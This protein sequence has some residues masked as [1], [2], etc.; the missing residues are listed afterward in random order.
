MG[1]NASVTGRTWFHGCLTAAMI[2][3]AIVALHPQPLRA[4]GSGVNPHMLDSGSCVSSIPDSA[5]TRT[6]VYMT[7]A[8]RNPIPQRVPS[9]IGNVMQAV[10]D[11]ADSALGSAPPYLPNGE[12]GVTWH[13]IGDGLLV[14]WHRDGTL[15]WTVNA[16]SGGPPRDT[17]SLAHVVAR[18]LAVT[19]ATGEV[20]LA[21]PKEAANDSVQFDV[22][23]ELSRVNPDKTL[24]PVDASFAIPILGVRAPWETPV[25]VLKQAHPIYPSELQREGVRATV[26]ISFVVDTSGRAD[27]AT[28]HDAWP[29]WRPR[30]TGRL[31][32]YYD[33]FYAAAARSIAEARF[34]PAT[35]AG[36]KVRQK[37]LQPFTWELR[38]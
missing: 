4:Q 21:W 32:R 23:F 1:S 9:M 12:P 8:V 7:V 18:S 2:A 3:A 24:A 10:V 29:S 36:C 6:V 16:D 26:R 33:Q 5:F 30:L 19:V 37:V 11:R 17:T 14:T 31:G 34:T 13:D 35:I 20:Y 28:I 27:P 25:A 15:T 38:Q 22:G